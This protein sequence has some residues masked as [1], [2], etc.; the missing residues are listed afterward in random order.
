MID[1]RLHALWGADGLEERQALAGRVV[2]CARRAGD[3]ELELRGL[4]WRFVAL[5]EQARVSD[6]ESALADYDRAVSLAGSPADELVVV[7]RHAMLAVLRGRFN[8]AHELI[9]RVE[10][11]GSTLGLADTASLV[12]TLR[13]SVASQGMDRSFR[14]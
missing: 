14:R 3:T 11:T 13:G 4:F 10:E 2:A 7:A 12:G 6:A 5:M 9:S 8:E 1:A